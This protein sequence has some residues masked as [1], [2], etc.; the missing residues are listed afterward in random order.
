MSLNDMCGAFDEND[1]M[2]GNGFI[3]YWGKD[4]CNIRLIGPLHVT[5]SH[6][7]PSECE[8]SKILSEEEW[9][10]IL[11]G[12][13]EYVSS[14]IKKIS[15]RALKDEERQLKFQQFTI[16]RHLAAV[17]RN[18]QAWPMHFI[19]NAIVKSPYNEH[20]S[21]S[22]LSV[23]R[24]KFECWVTQNKTLNGKTLI[25]GLYAHDMTIMNKGEIAQV[26][27]SPTWLDETAINDIMTKGLLNPVPF[28]KK[29]NKRAIQKRQGYLT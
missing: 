16:L 4:S 10:R 15:H 20:C 14:L 28:L 18:A 7:I 26:S 23:T 27:E 11:G 13:E 17:K 12:D 3:S 1:N 8:F 9:K 24:S 19:S 25:S 21:L 2:V 5:R 22:L 29:Q 6:Y